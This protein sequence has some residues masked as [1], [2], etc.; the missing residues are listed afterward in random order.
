MTQKLDLNKMGLVPINDS[1]MIKTNGGNNPWVLFAVAFIAWEIV[2]NP[3]AHY[4]AFM[5]GYNG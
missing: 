4:K 3:S 1:V 2:A 5:K